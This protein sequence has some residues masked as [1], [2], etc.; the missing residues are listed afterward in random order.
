M[1]AKKKYSAA[2]L[3][4]AVDKYF[5]SISREKVFTESVATGRKDGMG[6]EIYEEKPVVNFLGEELKVI[7]YLV[8]PTV[9][10][11]SAFLGV[12]R[13]TWN[14]WCDSSKYPEYAEVTQDAMGRI[15]SYLEQESLTRPGKDLKGVIF[16][17]E[18][19]YGYKERQK[20][21]VSGSGGIEE[22]LSSLAGSESR[23]GS[24]F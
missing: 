12:H 20:I 13:S 6:H 22:Y 9:G 21:E 7:E 11:L 23:G 18:N 5:R 2:G 4:K 8:P 16:N 17:L 14:A 19:N 24:E 3:Q 1:G 10:G 15:H